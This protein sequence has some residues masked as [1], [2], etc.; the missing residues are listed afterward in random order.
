MYKRLNFGLRRYHIG[1]YTA[2]EL[3]NFYNLSD[4]SIILLETHYQFKKLDTLHR[5]GGVGNKY[6][7][8]YKHED[9]YGSIQ[10]SDKTNMELI[11]MFNHNKLEDKILLELSQYVPIEKIAIRNGVSEDYIKQ[12]TL[13]YKPI[14]QTI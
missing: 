9:D 7:P 10:K 5:F 12:I 3:K 2:V 1:K 8:Y 13:D 11:L 4:E 14:K 6:E